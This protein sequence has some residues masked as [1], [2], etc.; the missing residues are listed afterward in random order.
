M[1]AEH[2]F[3]NNRRD[4][5]RILAAL[6]AGALL[7]GCPT[8]FR[9]EPLP[10]CPNSPDV[11]LLNGPLTIDAHCHVFNG[12]DLQIKEFF[13]RV[14]A[15]Q[16]GA[17]G[18][19]VKVLG[20]VLQNLAW[21]FAPSG[22]TEIAELRDLSAAL[23]TC[24]E[25]EHTARVSSLRQAGYTRGREQLQAAV[26]RSSEFQALLEK[27]RLG[28]LELDF[29]PE[30]IS[31][32]EA[33]RF[34][35]ELPPDVETY[36]AAKANK[37]LSTMALSGRSVQG[38]IDFVLQ[39]FQYRYVSIH[40]YLRTYNQKGVRVVDLMLPSMVDYDFWLAKGQGTLTPLRTQVELMQQMAIITG[41][42]VHGFVPF[43]PLRQV[44][45]DLKLTG[46]DS[47][48]LVTKAIEKMGCVG[49]KLYPPMG[50]AP[51]GNRGLDTK[52]GPPF[53]ERDWLP[54]WTSRPDLGARLDDAMSKMLS[55]CEANDVPVMAHTNISNGVIRD[56]ENL[57]GAEYWKIALKAYPKLRVSFGHFG[58]TSPV[59]DGLERARAFKAL[60]STEDATPGIHAYADAGYFVEVLGKEPALLTNLRQLYEDP[61]PAG[62]APLASRFMYGTD[63][64]MTLTEGGISGYLNDFVRLFDEL[65]A[66]PAIRQQGLTGLSDRFFGNNAANWIGLRSGNAARR[67]LDAFYALHNVPKPDWATK[68]D[69]G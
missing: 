12:T 38:L 22:D 48:G 20:S 19:G 10:V 28:T 56:F 18:A 17:L 41:G 13:S 6:P 37:N 39:N 44:A 15:R 33:I 62:R 47:Y 30:T 57:A 66:G 8:L 14:A 5:L 68:L 58:D 67:R 45:Y 53:W 51:L 21:S 2:F 9:R 32:V 42:R 31:K 7:A 64:E 43:D 59:E 23:R 4:I 54:D 26:A 49:V 29:D 65:E 36:R 16:S 55:W 40:D 61:V 11:S 27:R 34:I 63:W 50:F 69:A 46:D 1:S 35:E 25:K 24:T 52:S 3:K 60:M